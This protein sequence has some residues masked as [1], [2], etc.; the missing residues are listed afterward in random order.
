MRVYRVLVVHACPNCV[1]EWPGRLRHYGR[2]P[3]TFHR[4]PCASEY[5]RYVRTYELEAGNPTEAEAAALLHYKMDVPE[6][7]KEWLGI[8]EAAPIAFCEGVKVA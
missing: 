2:S 8:P 6:G 1:A 5:D 3:R 7:P 4:M